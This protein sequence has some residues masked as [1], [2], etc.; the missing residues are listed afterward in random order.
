MAQDEEAL[1]LKQTSSIPQGS[2]VTQNDRAGST[3]GPTVPLG[4][5]A[6]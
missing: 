5:M 3:A 1:K 6:V 2:S 4:T